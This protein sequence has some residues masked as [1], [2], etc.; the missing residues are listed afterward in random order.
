MKNDYNYWPAPLHK[1][2][3]MLKN[4]AAPILLFVLLEAV[5]VT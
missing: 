1:K 5:P 3:E 2:I 4:E